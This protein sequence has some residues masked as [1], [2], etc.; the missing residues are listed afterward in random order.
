MRLRI[1]LVILLTSK[2]LNF[3]TNFVRFNFG[4]SVTVQM[5]CQNQRGHKHTSFL[6]S[7]CRLEKQTRALVLELTDHIS[8]SARLWSRD[9]HPAQTELAIS[10][11]FL[12]D[13][14]WVLSLSSLRHNECTCTIRR[15]PRGKSKGLDSVGH[16]KAS[17]ATGA[18]A[19]L[20]PGH[21]SEFL[22]RV[23]ETSRRLTLMTRIRTYKLLRSLRMGSLSTLI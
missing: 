3:K 16:R 13:L 21:E 10:L 5:P 7:V 12:F 8:P 17:S 1:L 18:I 11:C 20:M 2:L 6:R 14:R 23:R 19:E 4:R 15:R 22:G 9:G